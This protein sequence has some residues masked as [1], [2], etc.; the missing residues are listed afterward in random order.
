MGPFN[1]NSDKVDTPVPNAKCKEL[2]FAIPRLV[3]CPGI[4]LRFGRPTLHSSI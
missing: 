2:F 3:F 1:L 4:G